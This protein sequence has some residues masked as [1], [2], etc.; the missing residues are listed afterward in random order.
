VAGITYLRTGVPFSV[1]FN[2]TQPGWRGGR[3]DVVS[4]GNLPRGERSIDR[5]FDPSGYRVPAPF[6]WGNSARNHLFG[7]GDIV[8]D[9][10]ILKNTPIT[11]RV[12]T[13][14]RAEFFNMPNHPNF[15]NPGANISVSQSLGRITSAGDP[16]QIQFGLKVLF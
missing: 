7:P 9:V 8:F 10:S 2:A 6:T 3:A 14:F 13:Q 16:R 15:G 5:W 11:E 4:V 1:G 12:T